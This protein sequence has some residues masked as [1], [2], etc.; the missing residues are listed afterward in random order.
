MID[1]N[2][3]FSAARAGAFGGTMTQGQVDGCGAILDGWESRPE[4]TD[5]RWL[6]YMLATAKH[7]T[8]HTMQPIEEYGKGAGHAYGEPVNGQ[9]YYG[10]GYVQLTWATNYARMAALTG[11]DLVGHPELALDPKIAALIMFDGMKGGLFTGVGLP[12]YFNDQTCDWVNA[13]R[14]INGTDRA[15]AIADIARAFYIALGA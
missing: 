15:G 5:L 1:R 8:A 11:V 9:I 3:F 14:I 4:F 6:A 10:R 7:E 12:R 13:R 2:R